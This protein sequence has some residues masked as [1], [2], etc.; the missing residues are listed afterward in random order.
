[1][2]SHSHRWVFFLALIAGAWLINETT[3]GTHRT[4]AIV[5]AAS[6]SA[7]LGVSDDTI[8]RWVDSGTLPSSTDES[9]RKVIAGDVLAG[10]ARDHASECRHFG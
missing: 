5:Y 10:F 4:G 7:L 1:M 2:W 3:P 9:G 8:R 6:V